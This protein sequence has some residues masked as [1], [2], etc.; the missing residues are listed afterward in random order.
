MFCVQNLLYCTTDLCLSVNKLKKK[1]KENNVSVQKSM[2]TKCTFCHLLKLRILT[3]PARQSIRPTVTHVCLPARLTICPFVRR[4]AR[5]PVRPIRPSVY[6]PPFP[7]P[8]V[9]PSRMSVRPSV[10]SSRT[11]L[12][13][14]DRPSNL[15]SAH[16]ARMHARTHVRPT[17]RSTDRAFVRSTDRH[18]RL[19]CVIPSDCLASDQPSKRHA[20]LQPTHRQSK[21]PYMC[22]S[23]RTTARPT[24]R[25][26]ILL[27]S[28]RPSDRPPART[29]RK[30]AT[31]V[32]PTVTH[33][34]H[35]CLPVGLT[36]YPSARPP[37]RPPDR[38]NGRP[39]VCPSDR[40]TVHPTDR[41]SVLP[42][43]C[44][45]SFPRPSVRPPW[46]MASRV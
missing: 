4:T 44:S 21:R 33:V 9:R 11:S 22:P 3:H 13:P 26:S 19:L 25:P 30:N 43:V 6:F 23:D 40:P 7:R 16:R 34:T 24:D 45:S 10:R 42:T 41:P 28:L 32:C 39:V 5:P 15:P 12:Q 1:E 8:S 37:V 35:V 18:A 14:T 29:A 31:H 38:P 46:C 20:R 27:L 2:S 17:D 36:I